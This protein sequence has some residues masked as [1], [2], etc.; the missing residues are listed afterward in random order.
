VIYLDHHAATPLASEVLDAM[1]H[2]QADGW[3]NPQ[4]VHQAGQRARALLEGA[5]AEVAAAIGA[6]PLDVVFTS[7]GTEACNLGVAGLLPEDLDGKTVLTTCVEHP[8]ML[9]AVEQL[10]RRGAKVQKLDVIAGNP[11]AIR[12]LSALIDDSTVL[13][14]VQ[15]VNHETGN[16]FP[17]ADY[18]SVLAE[19]GVPLLVDG[20]QAVGRL[21]VDVQTLPLA[22]LVLAAS[23]IGGPKGAG[24]LWVE[25]CRELKPLFAGGA[26]EKGRRPGTPAV[27]ELVGLGAAARLMPR[28]LGEMPRLSVLR[29]RLEQAAVA[30]GGVVNGAGGPRVAS[31]TNLSF[32]KWRGDHLVAAL[33]IEGL[34]AS[35]GAACSSGLGAPSP[36]LLAMYPDEPWRAESALRLSLGPETT[37]AEVEA[38][39]SVLE[40]VL[41]RVV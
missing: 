8:A 31:V 11:P 1:G 19:R 5:R 6:K 21:P 34:C 29:D 33:D 3:A 2:A 40:R 10:A 17:I 39:V 41:G 25:R 4:S 32:R 23:K 15:W 38:A 20:C 35:S 18:A 12:E 28:R 37:R 22:G 16:I 24:A 36:V 27:V 7:G 13:A 30:L 14:V 26:Q 9:Q